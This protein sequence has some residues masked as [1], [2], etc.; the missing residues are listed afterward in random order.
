LE[1][2]VATIDCGGGGGGGGSFGTVGDVDELDDDDD[3]DDDEVEADELDEIE[4]SLRFEQFKR[5]EMRSYSQNSFFFLLFNFN[6]TEFCRFKS[7]SLS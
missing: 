4:I 3:D 2:L 1:T 7:N 5:V 6:L